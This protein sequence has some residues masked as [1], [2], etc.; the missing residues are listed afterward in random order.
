MRSVA[1]DDSAAIGFSS[2]YRPTLSPPPV[3]HPVEGSCENGE[4]PGSKLRVHLSSRPSACSFLHRESSSRLVPRVPRAAAYFWHVCPMHLEESHDLCDA[5]EK[6]STSP[7][8]KKSN[9]RSSSQRE[10]QRERVLRSTKIIV[11]LFGTRVKRREKRYRHLFF[12]RN[13]IRVCYTFFFRRSEIQKLYI[14][15]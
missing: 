2:M 3:P 9:G 6:L 14:I 11:A 15:F 4:R 13:R 10:R 1:Y 5:V 12:S 8:G 7:G